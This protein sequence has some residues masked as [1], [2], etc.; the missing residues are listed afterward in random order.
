MRPQRWMAKSNCQR[1]CNSMSILDKTINEIH[2]SLVKGEVTPLELTKEAIK[3][4]KENKDNAIEILNE[5]EALAFASCLKE[6]EVDN[7]LWGIPYFCKDNFSTKG[8]ET[9]ASSNILNGYIP[10]FDAT[11]VAKLKDKKAILIG[12]STL[13]ELAMGG[14]GTT[15]HKGKTFNPYDETHTRMVG[16]SSCGSASLVASSVVPFATGSDTGD[17]IRKPASFSGLVGIKPTWGR[18]SRFG[19]FPFAPSLDHVGYF[20]R[21]VLDSAILLNALAGRDDKDSTSSVE[22]VEDYT[23]HI[24]DSIKGKKIAV[25]KEIVDSISDKYLLSSFSKAVEKLKE[26]GACVEY[27]SF[28]LDLLKAIYP[29]YIVISCAEATSNDANLDGIKFGPNYGGNSYQE[30]MS[31]ARTKG[32]SELIKRRFVIGSFALMRENQN[33]LFLRAQKIRRKI[34]DK[35]NEILTTYDAIFAPAAPGVAPRFEDS[36]DKLSS[37]YLIADNYLAIG[38]FAGLPSITLPLTKENGLPIGVNFTTR[39]FEESLL[40]NIAN[41]FEEISGLNNLSVNNNKEGNL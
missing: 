33:E 37:E 1:W 40:F 30:V 20:T 25:I 27:V 31:N 36:G 24:N 13:D 4:A 8:L 10:L 26:E 16:G 17:S 35:T 29:V 19:L 14:T 21:S 18:I 38:N 32:F 11:V 28:P 12:K 15:G 39:K 23:A 6:V 7:P 5:E 9:T 22:K 34:V 41:K 3:R 2:S